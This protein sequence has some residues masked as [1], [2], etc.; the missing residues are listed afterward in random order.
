[1]EDFR[2]YPVSKQLKVLQEWKA[3]P[4]ELTLLM[5]E[6][7]RNG[8]VAYEAILPHL[9]GSAKGVPFEIAAEAAAWI[10]GLGEDLKGTEVETALKEM[11]EHGSGSR[12]EA[13]ERALRR[14]QIMKSGLMRPCYDEADARFVERRRRGGE[15]SPE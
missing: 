13:A 4:E 11:M 9:R 12:S 10:H 6:F 3:R 2:R 8:D 1:L 5:R 14:I 15:G 7:A